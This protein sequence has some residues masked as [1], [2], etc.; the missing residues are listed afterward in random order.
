VADL[1]ALL[2]ASLARSALA[3]SVHRIE[4]HSTDRVLFAAP[5]LE[6][7]AWLQWIGSVQRELGIRLE[8]C[9]I[10]A[11]EEPGMVRIEASFVAGSTGGR[12]P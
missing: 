3:K 2:R 6:F 11:L 7:D 8:T 5:V 10:T 12:A 1:R 9:N 4:W